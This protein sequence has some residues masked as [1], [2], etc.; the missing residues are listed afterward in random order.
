MR[1]TPKLDLSQP[2]KLSAN[3][4]TPLTR[5]PW[6]GR[7]I[8][9]RYKKSF[10]EDPDSTRIGESWEVSCDPAFLSEVL[11]TGMSLVDLIATEPE[12]M[13]SAA[14]VAQNGAKV[15][16]LI[17]LINAAEPLSVQVHPTDDDPNLKPGECGKPE[18][19]LVLHAEPGSGLYLGFSK[20]I[21]KVELKSLIEGGEDL[22]PFLQ[23][24]PVKEGDYFEIP[25]GVVHAIGPGIT[26]LEP[27]RVQVG[28]AGKTYRFWDW[29]RRYNPDGTPNPI[30]GQPRELHVSEGLR[31]VESEMQFGAGYVGSLRGRA[32]ILELSPKVNHVFYPANAYYQVH[33]LQMSAGSQVQ[34]S[35]KS[36]FLTFVCLGGLGVLGMNLKVSRGEPGFIPFAALP[37]LI[38]VAED[39][40]E[41][42]DLAVIIP[43]SCKLKILAV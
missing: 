26:L 23:F 34:L 14:Y 40:K 12:K 29:L 28:K 39:A 10:V 9:K 8:A 33:R 19:W 17:K 2:L 22:K 35:A 6:A 13:L 42:F 30:S 38:D 32:E 37:L 21:L 15:E 20:P 43:S 41:D 24:V 1:Q 27:Q 18:S 31:I 4:F 5:T 3:L 25:P 16:I 7:E 36:G 11:G